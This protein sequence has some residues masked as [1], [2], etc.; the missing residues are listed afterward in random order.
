[1]RYTQRSVKF[2]ESRVAS[3]G[4]GLNL[5]WEEC[6]VSSFLA[7]SSPNELGVR[8]QRVSKEEA[9]FEADCKDIKDYTK[10]DPGLDT[11]GC[12]YRLLLSR[13]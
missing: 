1:M 13:I 6:L 12:S 3:F 10:Y 2:P 9:E 7:P 4:L 8:R 5:A 11:K